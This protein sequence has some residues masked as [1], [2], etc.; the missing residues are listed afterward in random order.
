M[1]KDGGRAP[2]APETASTNS[3]QTWGPRLRCWRAARF[4]GPA[5]VC[6]SVCLLAAAAHPP[7]HLHPTPP[8]PTP[9]PNTHT[10][11]LFTLCTC[12]HTRNPTP[13]HRPQ[14]GP[15]DDVEDLKDA[16][17][18][19][20]QDIFSSVD[21]T[22]ARGRGRR[23]LHAQRAQRGGPRPSEVWA[24]GRARALACTAPGQRCCRA[25]RADPA[26][27]RLGFRNVWRFT[28]HPPLP[29]QAR[30]CA[31]RHLPWVPWRRCLS[32]SSRMMFG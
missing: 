19:D 27:P 9:L 1:V 16:V 11:T 32:S 14:V 17:M 30:A 4:A 2:G 12:V 7:P 29:P 21:K 28:R 18:E 31:C 22:G 25:R 3:P 26:L 20:M 13:N 8:H 24:A 10:H 6:S 23:A 5:L 15:D